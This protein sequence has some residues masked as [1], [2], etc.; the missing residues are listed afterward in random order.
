MKENEMAIYGVNVRD[1][2]AVGDGAADDGPAFQRALDAGSPL[3]AVPFGIYKI[4]QPL[5][6]GSDTEIRAH[7]RA[8]IRIDDHVCTHR[9]DFLL[10]NKDHQNGDR[11]IIITGG[12]WNGNNMG[13][14]RGEL[15]DPESVTGTM[16]NFRKV[17][18][19]TLS[20][21]VLID[22]QC[23]YIR[24]CEVDHFLVEHIRFEVMH[25]TRNQDGVHLAGFCKNGI[26][27]HLQASPDATNDDLVALNADDCMT[28]LQN[29]D[30]LCGPIENIVVHDIYADNCHCF[31][32][33]LSVDSYIH[34]V[35]ISGVRGGCKG[36]LVNMDAARYCMTPLIKKDEPRYT[37]GVGDVR[38]VTVSDITA[39][40][41]KSGKALFCL[42]T[43]LHNFTVRNYHFDEAGSA[44]PFTPAVFVGNNADMQIE[45]NGVTQDQVDKLSDVSQCRKIEIAQSND[46]YREKTYHVT[47]EKGIGE[48]FILPSGGFDELYITDK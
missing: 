10:T 45:M 43:N 19:L 15:F 6:I 5:R 32:R 12:I 24:L 33:L 14:P 23:Y 3:V 4:G 31:V 38:D 36:F 2:G 9:G 44:K 25:L 35:D 48:T 17:E 16:L 27:R 22:P 20:G 47:A 13:N 28:R 37:Q 40:S 26:I 46:P 42:E 41:N 29:L 39:H 30:V 8:V 1:F 21:M 34:N 18:N 7:K 11:N